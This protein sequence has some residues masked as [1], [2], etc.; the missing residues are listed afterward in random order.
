MSTNSDEK[1][2]PEPGRWVPKAEAVQELEISLSTLDRRIRAGEIEAVRRG[3]RVY[4]RMHGPEYLSDAEQLLR[5]AIVREDEL[6]RTVRRLERAA[7]ELEQQRDEAKKAA[8]A[9]REAYE[10]LEEA[11]RREHA[12]HGRTR[13]V[14]LR[15]GL[16]A[17]TLFVL[18]VISV[19]VTWR[20]FT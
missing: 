1:E 8:F 17:V 6:E 9:S 12:M 3:R 10:E 5:R 2:T 14:A 13:R 15:L 11:Y 20:L 4:V 19:L 18:L 7:S 16:V